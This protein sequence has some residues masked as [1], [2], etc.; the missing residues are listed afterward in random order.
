MKNLQIAKSFLDKIKTLVK[1]KHR[2]FVPRTYPE[3]KGYLECLAKLGLESVD[4]AWEYI[5]ELDS[6]N[7]FSGPEKD[8]TDNSNSQAEVIWTFKTKIEG[9]TTYIKLKD[10]KERRGCVCLSF[11]LDNP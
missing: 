6:E 9:K 2:Y 5:L 1:Q 4:E 10:E 8:F 7:Y 3:G 11:H